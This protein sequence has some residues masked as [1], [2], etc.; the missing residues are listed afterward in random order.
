MLNWVNRFNIFCFLD[1]CDYSLPFHSHDCIAGAGSYKSI[2]VNAGNALSSLEKFRASS[3]DWCFGHLGYDLKNEIDGLSSNKADR[4]GF[5]DLCFFIPEVVLQ[6]K[7][8]ELIIGV[9]DGNPE[10]IYNELCL[11]PVYLPHT[12]A[13]ISNI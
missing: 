6:L 10:S 3:N 4:I 5:D 7:A 12:S 8:N 1:S 11:Q 13:N 2:S 9:L